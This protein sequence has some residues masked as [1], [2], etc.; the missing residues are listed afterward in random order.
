LDSPSDSHDKEDHLKAQLWTPPN[1]METEQGQRASLMLMH[2][3]PLKEAAKEAAPANAENNLA[4]ANTLLDEAKKTEEVAK[5][6]ELAA[7]ATLAESK[8]DV[9]LALKEQHLNTKYDEA[10][11]AADIISQSSE[12]VEALA[13]AEV[14]S[15]VSNVFQ[16]IG[17][18]ITK[19]KDR[20]GGIKEGYNKQFEMEK[21]RLG[22]LVE[23]QQVNNTNLHQENEKLTSQA[24]A[25]QK[26]VAELR[27]HAE[28]TR[29]QD[30]RLQFALDSMKA[31]LTMVAE[32]VDTSDL[33]DSQA[34]ETE[35]LREM[36]QRREEHQEDNARSMELREIA[37]RGKKAKSSM[38][39]VDAHTTK[40]DK[41]RAVEFNGSLKNLQDTV[42]TL[43]QE[44]AE[45]MKNLRDLSNKRLNSKVEQYEALMAERQ[46]IQNRISALEETHERLASASE[47][48]EAARKDLQQRWDSVKGYT[49]L[50]A[51]SATPAPIGPNAPLAH[52][53]LDQ[54][55]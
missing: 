24:E 19:L 46:G 35:V 18:Q 10:A 43:Q 25:T 14:E 32:Y 49:G 5:K 11:R 41:K 47:H 55:S 50:L 1:V 33:D 9:E 52:Q 3:D 39:Q 48:L 53:P 8:E 7:P 6:E 44:H 29:S 15:H 22:L 54:S 37:G 21:S 28:E 31:N 45:R 27:A 13:T 17:S 36:A 12:Q 51:A 34:T 16:A 20:I 23:M 2:A 42:K 26:K 38:M 30:E 4:V 40:Q